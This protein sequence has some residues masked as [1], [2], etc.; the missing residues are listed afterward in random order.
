MNRIESIIFDLEGVVV[1]SEP[2]WS[3]VDEEFLKRQGLDYVDEDWKP[4]LMGKSLVDGSRLFKERLGLQPDA[5]AIAQIRRAIARE[6]L[7]NA[8]TFIP[9][10]EAFFPKVSGSFKTAVG[11]GME[12]ELF[13]ILDARLNISEMFGGRVYSIDDIGRIS[14][15]NPDIFL[16]VAG[17]LGSAPLQCVVIEDSPNGVEAA[18]RA[19]MYCV[20][21]TTTTPREKLNRANQI[22]NSYDEIDLAKI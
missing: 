1:D 19:G 20:A 7:Q 11:T 17:K 6:Q 10:F 4:L 18:K 15:P 21:L 12:R 22:V 9:G 8:V 2:L 16:Y 14:K 13:A 3:K 5:E